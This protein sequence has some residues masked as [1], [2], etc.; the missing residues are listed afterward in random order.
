[1]TLSLGTL[2][3][4]TLT[5]IVFVIFCRKF[6]WPPI[7]NAMHER[8]KAIAEGLSSA[9]RA[10]KDLELAQ[11]RVAEQLREAK[12]EAQQIIEQARS[13][14]NQMIDEAKSDA[15]EE[16]ERIKEAAR[17]EIEQEVNRAKETLRAQ[18]ASLSV[19]GAERVL[20]ASVD[21]EKHSE[22]LTQLAADL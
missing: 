7:I 14:A 4:Q 10:E 8:Q 16:G 20:A 19:I 18:V 9:E 17:S 5:F 22:L 13:R 21:A 11:E 6:I 12:G 3:G 2:I 15:R 1:M